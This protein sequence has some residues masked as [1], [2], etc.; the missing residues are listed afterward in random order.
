MK[1][2]ELRIANLVYNEFK[3]VI[4]VNSIRDAGV[5]G[6]SIETIKPIPLTEEWLLKFG[7]EVIGTYVNEGILVTDYGINITDCNNDE[8]L[9]VSDW[10]MDV[11][12]GDYSEDD[13]YVCNFNY[14]YVHQLQNLYHALTGKE[15]KTKQND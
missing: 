5:N 3:E 9:I 15:L 11:S 13:Y 6:Y 12:I 10:N 8:K 2:S 4:T 1:A 14:Q 7:F